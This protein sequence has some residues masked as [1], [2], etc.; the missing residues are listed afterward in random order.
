MK[1]TSQGYPRNYTANTTGDILQVAE[2]I[3]FMAKVS[4]TPFSLGI[5]RISY[6]T[7]PKFTS[8]ILLLF[9][10]VLHILENLLL[11]N[12]TGLKVVS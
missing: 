6:L 2:K 9:S 5:Y 10:K 1:N 3:Y 7:M 12:F 4:T 8:Q 11:K